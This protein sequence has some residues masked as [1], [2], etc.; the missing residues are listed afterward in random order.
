MIPIKLTPGAGDY[1]LT[2]KIPDIKTFKKLLKLRTWKQVSPK[3][4][5]CSIAVPLSGSPFTPE[6]AFDYKRAVV[7]TP[8]SIS[9][10][11]K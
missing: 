8:R 10:K 7:I 4:R 6:G 3:P 1:N 11:F 2:S 5:D 9:K